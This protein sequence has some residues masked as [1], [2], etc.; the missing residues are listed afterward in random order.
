LPLIM[1]E[2]VITVAP[3]ASSTIVL[4]KGVYMWEMV[5]IQKSTQ[6]KL[7]YWLTN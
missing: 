5:G 3:Q 4:K 6:S 7:R 2:Q 1:S